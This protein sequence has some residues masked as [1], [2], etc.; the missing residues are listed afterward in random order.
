MKRIATEGAVVLDY[1]G[2]VAV[3][4]ARPVLARCLDCGAVTNAR[5]HAPHMVGRV[6]VDCAGRPC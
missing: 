5:P 2:E 4:V 1:T 6:L 3:R